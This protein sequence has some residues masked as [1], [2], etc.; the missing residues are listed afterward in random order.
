MEDIK[1]NIEGVR[2]K[3]SEAAAAAG[4][5]EVPESEQPAPDTDQVELA[6]SYLETGISIKGGE[7]DDN[8]G[9]DPQ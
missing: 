6:K 7:S 1:K 4:R 8:D 5:E 9:E 2:A 3:I